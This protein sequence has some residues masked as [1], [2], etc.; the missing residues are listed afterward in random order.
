ML[1]ASV[2]F[3]E[4]NDVLCR[5][6]LEASQLFNVEIMTRRLE[7]ILDRRESLR[8]RRAELHRGPA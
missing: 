6:C 8:K 3:S 1:H 4:E 7:L 5:I 2:H